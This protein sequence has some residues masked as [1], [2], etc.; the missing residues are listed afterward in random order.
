MTIKAFEFDRIVRKLEMSTRKGADRHAWLEYEGRIIIRTRRSEKK[1]DLPFSHKIRQQLRLN[2][3]QFGRLI[4]C[5]LD[6]DG[7]LAILQ[8]KGLL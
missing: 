3:E 4:G 8:E 5:S 1:G 6:R 2:E 7:Y